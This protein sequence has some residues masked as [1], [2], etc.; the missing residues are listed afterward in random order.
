M[1][2]K[3]VLITGANG[4]L[5]A[6]LVEEFLSENYAVIATDKDRTS[7][8][9]ATT[10]FEYITHDFSTD[11]MGKLIEE[12]ARHERLDCIINNAALTGTSTIQGW[13]TEFNSQTVEAALQAF[14]INTI[15]PVFLIRDTKPLWSKSVRPAVVNIGSIYGQVSPNFKLYEN[16]DMRFPVF[17][18]ASKAALDSM[19]KFLTSYFSPHLRVNTV[20]PGGIARGQ[21]SDFIKRY[22]KTV[23]LNR[24]ATEADVSKLVSFLCSDES[25][26]INGQNIVVDGGKLSWS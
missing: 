25:S 12:L 20:S 26:Y 6:S 15:S 4:P 18:S 23:P 17:Y 24:M 11:P 21:P 3:R 1:A 13:A 19:T 16:T 22:V 7:R 2:D 8:N 5:G 14:L 10:K 9:I